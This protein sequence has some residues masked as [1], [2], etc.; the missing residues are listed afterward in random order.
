MHHDGKT[1]QWPNLDHRLKTNKSLHLAYEIKENI[2]EICF[3]LVFQIS[4]KCAQQGSVELGSG[5]PREA[6]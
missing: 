3:G 2:R 4:Y 6:K 5:R 1:K